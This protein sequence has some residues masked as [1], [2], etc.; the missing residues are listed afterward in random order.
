MQDRQASEQTGLRRPILA[1]L[2]RGFDSVALMAIAPVTAASGA[3][4]LPADNRS[5]YSS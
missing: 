4:T 5:G 1:D 3:N 2:R